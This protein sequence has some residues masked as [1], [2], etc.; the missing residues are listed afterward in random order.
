MIIFYLLTICVV[1]GIEASATGLSPSPQPGYLPALNMTVNVRTLC[2]RDFGFLFKV[3]AFPLPFSFKEWWQTVGDS[4]SSYAFPFPPKADPVCA[5]VSFSLCLCIIFLIGF[6]TA[7]THHSPAA[8][9]QLKPSQ[10][11]LPKLVCRTLTHLTFRKL[12]LN[13]KYKQQSLPPP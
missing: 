7:T 6:L 9:S 4:R 1:L 3:T 11:Q 8:S 13:L 5:G 2:P 12:G 10:N